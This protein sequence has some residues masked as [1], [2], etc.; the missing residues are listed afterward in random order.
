MGGLKTE[1][2]GHTFSGDGADR[3][4][5]NSSRNEKV[6]GTSTARL[7][8]SPGLAILKRERWIPAEEQA[9]ANGR[10]DSADSSFSNG[11][12][13]YAE[14]VRFPVRQRPGLNG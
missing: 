5:Y 2:G 8:F 4:C 13:Y 14:E 1:M 3:R 12:G 10:P 9:Q 6:K 7:G 11:R